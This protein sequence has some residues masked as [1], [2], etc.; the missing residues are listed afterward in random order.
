MRCARR[1]VFVALTLALVAS[2]SG[3]AGAQTR[4]PRRFQLP[5]Q[6]PPAPEGRQIEAADGDTL[7]VNGDDRVTVIRRRQA[8]V[9]VVATPAQRTV[10]VLADW[11]TPASNSPDGVVDQTWIFRD[12]E[13][14]WPF[15][16]RWQGAV[17]LLEPEVTRV[18]SGARP[19][20]TLIVETPVGRVLFTGMPLVPA[21]VDGATV[22]Q[23]RGMSGSGQTGANF[24]DAERDAAAGR[25]GGGAGGFSWSSSSGSGSGGIGFTNE[26]VTSGGFAPAD[27]AGMVM[28][29][30]GSAP[31]GAPRQMPRPVHRVTPSWPDPAT[32][33][34]VRGVV[35]VRVVV[36]ADGLVKDVVVLRGLPGL[37]EAAVAAARQWR[38]EPTGVD[39]R[40][41][42]I[43]WPYPLHQ[44]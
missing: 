39:D 18:A 42:A 40:P 44:R 3:V 9:R 36:G 23:H 17:T 27:A 14:Q 22:I 11:G 35:S 31:R 16:A 24:D 38:F 33:P 21:P 13:G 19:Q 34:A 20:P 43:V 4:P 15:E 41:F 12:V 1:P 5:A 25:I 37:D 26:T 29:L 32:Q 8:E 2:A 7:I 6:R 10:I 28:P 30:P